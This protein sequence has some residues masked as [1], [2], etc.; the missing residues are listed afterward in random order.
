MRLNRRAFLH[1]SL[2][3]GAIAIGSSFDA[4]ASDGT[5]AAS[6]VAVPLADEDGY[7]LWLRY[8]PV[9]DAKLRDRY[10]QTTSQLV[11]SAERPISESIVSELDL[12]CKGM[13]GQSPS[14]EKSV[15]VDGTIFI[16]TPKS[17]S[18]IQKVIDGSQLAS[19]GDEGYVLKS[20]KADG[21]TVTI[22]AANTERGLLYGTFALIKLMQLG[23]PIDSLDITDS[24]RANIRMVNHWD[25]MGRTVTRGYAGLSIF[26]FSDLTAPNPRYTDYARLLASIGINGTAINNVNASS[27]FL[28]TGMM[29]GYASLAA[30]LRRWGIRL[31]L[32]INFAAPIDLTKNDA[33]PIVTADPLDKR[34]QDWWA[35]KIDEIYQAVPD[36]GGF[37]VK[38]NSEGEPGPLTYNRTHADGANML[39]RPLASHGGILIWRSFVHK[40][41]KGWSEFEYQTFH[42][43]DGQFD[44]NVIIQTKNGPIDFQALEPVNPLFGAMPKTNQ[45]IELEISQEYTGHATHLCYL[46]TYWSKVLGFE[47]HY[48]SGNGPT[49]GEVVDGSADK[50]TLT[51]FA[52][53]INFGDDRNWTGS[54]LAAAN[55]HGFGRLAWDHTLAVSDI[56]T[57]WTMRT[58]GTDQQVVSTIVPM[59]QSSW[60]TYLSYT[61]PFGTG[62]IMR[63]TGAHYL[64]D[65]RGTQH[66]SH[67]TDSQG[68][69]FDRTLAT[70]SG[71]T[72][73]Y[74]DY[75]FDR[76][77]HIDSCP[78]DLLMFMHIV[79]W[80]HKLANGNTVIQQ[81]YD[82][83]FSGVDQVEA[84]E[85]SWQSLSG[86]ID[87]N[88]YTAISK[89]FQRQAFQVRT[90]RDVLVSYYFDNARIV[91][92]ANPWIQLEIKESPALLFG[93]IANDFTAQ[94]SNATPD[95]QKI[96]VAIDPAHTGWKS[97]SAE[98]ELGARKS[99]DVTLS[100]TPPVEPYLGAVNFSHDPA[101]LNT[102]GFGTQIMM[103]TPDAKKCSLA[104]DIGAKPE[105]VVP[106]YTSIRAANSWSDSANA[107]WVGEPPNDT[108]LG[109]NWG[110]LQNHC[111]S[112]GKAHTLRLRLPAGKQRAWALIGGQGSGTQPVRIS[113]GKESL[114]ETSYLEESTFRWAPFTLDG[115]KN[116]KTVDLTITG[117][118]GRNWRLSA[119]V[120]LQPGL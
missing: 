98:K 33:N 70:G 117:D 58:F 41:F 112:G 20:T 80:D 40:G 84:M 8:R 93:G 7:E 74:S 29:A 35:K 120:V 109:D 1:S 81:I 64:P 85:T 30:I 102:L 68:S 27:D 66:L 39:A 69:G 16:G 22:I 43:L 118:D 23:Q 79:P 14:L 17:S 46:P 49:V 114:T 4:Y 54:Y 44:K 18:T 61:T 6:P 76:Y 59:L 42:T 103:V 91:S 45:M 32:S 15:T 113:Q 24:P 78:E 87:T 28:G 119:L 116:G 99:A 77:E 21:H 12:A 63:P 111:A 51:G 38:A 67:F 83:H 96:K 104:L 57:E 75:W 100:I 48:D 107:G 31:Y 47:T 86:K 108:W 90:W 36:C 13:L 37:L 82:D 101:T 106:G 26:Q 19:L 62:Y 34:V 65:P 3:A 71:F 11:V 110:L 97:N 55:T 53:V 92:T 60:Q 5:P 50:E 94:F 95:S 25:S 9:T 105:S 73:L 72:R 89:Q 115:G 52:G 10:R 2:M 88:R 56:A